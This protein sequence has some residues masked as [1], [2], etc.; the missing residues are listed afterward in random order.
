MKI[1]VV[2]GGGREH[3]I[4]WAL[5]KSP[6][7]QQIYCAPG[8]GGTAQV[9]QNI[10]I[11]NTDFDGLIK[12]AKET[13]IDL[14]ICPMDD[15]L[16]AGIVDAF[17]AA[18]LRIFGP[19]KAAAHIEGSKVYAKAFMQKYGIPTAEYAA[20]DS[21][22]E[23]NEYITGAKLPFV[24]KTDGL[25]AGKG[26]IICHTLDE[27]RQALHEIFVDGRFGASGQQ[28][29]IEEFLTGVECSVLAFCDGRTIVPMP[30]AKDHKA[31]YDGDTGPNTGGM[32]VLAPNPYY[33]ERIAKECME[34]L[35]IPTIDG[36]RAEGR[37][38]V[39]VMFFGLMITADGVKMLEYNCRPGDPE[40]QALL[41][42]LETDLLDI[43]LACMD[44]KLDTM[45]VNWKNN[46][47]CCVIAAS[48]GY[49]GNYQT[50]YPISGL[51]STGGV[52]IFHSGTKAVDGNVVTNGGRVLSVVATAD[53][54]PAARS[55]AY[56]AMAGL[57]FRD[58]YYRKD[59]G[60]I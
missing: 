40:T 6:K 55:A 43:I 7:I 10:P 4:C 25:A 39:G 24:I 42:L 37:E 12:F 28:V 53:F 16:V 13:A 50:G 1:L 8:N 31:A 9:A 22:A 5:A 58:M 59:I 49:P 41:P 3:A 34:K 33:T 35:F 15:P 19:T 57:N 2:G 23:A 46:A 21:L 30:G 20:F 17:Q 26:V 27:A 45:D 52:L 60:D 14:T 48:G 56:N 54:A 47:V 51:G 36:L 29:V 38:F 32:G 11:V 44:K 18:G